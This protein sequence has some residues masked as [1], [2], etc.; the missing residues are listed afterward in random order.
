MQ[1]VPLKY[2]DWGQA[3][4]DKLAS[5]NIIICPT[6]QLLQLLLAGSNTALV[7]HEIQWVPLDNGYYGGQVTQTPSVGWMT[8]PNGHCSQLPVVWL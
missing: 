2:W 4:T 1:L 5:F 7:G 3:H 8:E 6:P